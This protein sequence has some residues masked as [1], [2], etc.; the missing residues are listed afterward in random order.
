MHMV[1]TADAGEYDNEYIVTVTLA[2]NGRLV[3]DQYD[4]IDS[5]VQT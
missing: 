4:F 1:A 3:Q 5:Q 2:E